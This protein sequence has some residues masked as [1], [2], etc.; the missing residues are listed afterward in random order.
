MRRK[1]LPFYDE[2]M[3]KIDMIVIH[4]V[5]YP[6]REAIQTFINNKVSSH[7]VIGRDGEVWQLVGEKKRAWHAGKSFWRGVDGIN[8]HAVGIELC[9]PNLG[10]TAFSK[11]QKQALTEMLK[12]LIKKY[13]IRPENIVG[14]SDIA[15]TRKPD[16][17]K[18][19]FWKE[20]ADKGIGLWYEVKD[21]AKM[22]ED[23]PEKLLQIIGYDTADIQAALYAFCRHFV[24]EVVPTVKDVNNLIE[25]PVDRSLDL[26]K[27]K[28]VL[29]VLKAVAYAYLNASKTPCKM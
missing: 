20:L 29:K 27:D 13:C 9:S 3:C 18:A 6:P 17:G 23:K 4:A 8:A 14:H 19:F 2:R 24:P 16:P 1:L 21:A 12:R 22:K 11:E 25:M 26:A 10:Q 7:Y 5:A 28:K 15:P